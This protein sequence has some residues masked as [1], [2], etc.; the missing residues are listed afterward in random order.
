MKY[1]FLIIFLVQ[2]LTTSDDPI[3]CDFHEYEIQHFG[4]ELEVLKSTENLTKY[5]IKEY[6]PNTRG[7]KKLII[8][9]FT[10]FL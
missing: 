1:V 2:N 7:N 10:H 8:T 6:V 5:K 9:H 3:P 4:R